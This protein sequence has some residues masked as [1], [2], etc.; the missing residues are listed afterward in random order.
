M[1]PPFGGPDAYASGELGLRH[2]FL[3]DMVLPARIGVHA[4]EHRGEQRVRINIDLAVPDE[5]GPDALARVVDY[6]AIA[7]AV[8]RIVAAGHVRLV[9]TLAERIAQSCLEDVRVRIV[10]VCVEKLDVF[11]DSVSAGVAIERRAARIVH[12]PEASP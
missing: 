5:A 4:H 12:Q 3:R 1:R 7:N 6:E 10:R 11:A 8:R 9:E 2:V